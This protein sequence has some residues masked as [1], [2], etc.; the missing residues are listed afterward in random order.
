MRFRRLWAAANRGPRLVARYAPKAPAGTDHLVPGEANAGAR[1][2]LCAAFEALTAEQWAAVVRVAGCD[3]PSGKGGLR[4]LKDALD[5]L[6]D[7]W[8]PDRPRGR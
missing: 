4:M 2:E 8:D 6:A 5:R 3:E 1:A 7:M